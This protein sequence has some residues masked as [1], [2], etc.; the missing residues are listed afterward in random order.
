VRTPAVRPPLAGDHPRDCRWHGLREPRRDETGRGFRGEHPRVSWLR[1]SAAARDVRPAG[2]VP[3]ALASGRRS[4][5]VP[6]GR[7]PPDIA[8]D[9]E[10]LLV[11]NDLTNSLNLSDYKY[12]TVQVKTTNEV[13]KFSASFSRLPWPAVNAQSVGRATTWWPLTVAGPLRCPTG[14]PDCLR[15]PCA[16]NTERGAHRAQ[17]SRGVLP[18]SHSHSAGAGAA[19]GA[20]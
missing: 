7:L 20:G 5:H 10:K 3:A 17:N 1:Q 2:A 14:A 18:H 13:K 19:G 9:V 4:K 15:P 8:P 12:D 16:H 6:A 11:K